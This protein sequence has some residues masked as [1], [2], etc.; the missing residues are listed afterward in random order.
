MKWA[1]VNSLPLC[2]TKDLGL[3]VHLPSHI[4][5]LLLL[6]L[7]FYSNP[8]RPFLFLQTLFNR[9]TLL[10]RIPILLTFKHLLLAWSSRGLGL[11][12]EMF[13]YN[14]INSTTMRVLSSRKPFCASKEMHLLTLEALIG[15]C[16]KLK[17]FVVDFATSTNMYCYKHFIVALDF[18]SII[19]SN[20]LFLS[21]NSVLACPNLSQH[22]LAL[23]GDQEVFNEVLYL[24]FQDEGSQGKKIPKFSLDLESPI[25]KHSKIDLECK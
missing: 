21:S 3:K 19:S 10:V 7:V 17:S 25:H 20:I 22:I 14:W 4:F 15:A 9:T 6:F 23:D 18:H 5:S 16:L 1:M 24:L 13:F 8:Q 2:N 12:R 11:Q